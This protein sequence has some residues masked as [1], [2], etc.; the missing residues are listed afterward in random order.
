M[1]DKLYEDNKD[2]KQTIIIF[3]ILISF[4][5][6]NSTGIN[7]YSIIAMFAR[8][9]GMLVLGYILGNIFFVLRPKDRGEWQKYK[10]IV[11]IALIDALCILGPLMIET[12]SR[13]FS[14]GYNRGYQNQIE[15]MNTK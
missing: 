11:L 13:S 6:I 1:N 4:L 15:K 12:A 5:F 14:A 7:I 3:I 2:K 10:I 9:V 8:L